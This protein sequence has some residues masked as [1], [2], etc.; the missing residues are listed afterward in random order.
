MIEGTD[1]KPSL[2]CYECL[3]AGRVALP[4]DTAQDGEMAGLLDWENA[5]ENTVASGLMWELLRTPHYVTWQGEQWQ[6]DEGQPMIYVGE[7]NR[8]AFNAHAPNGDGKALF[9]EI[10]FEG[11]DAHWEYLADEQPCVYVFR[12]ATREKWAAHWDMD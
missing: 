1:D 9:D 7:W 10:V 2:V 12:S 11:M 6:F 8:A 5:A 4:K 3:R